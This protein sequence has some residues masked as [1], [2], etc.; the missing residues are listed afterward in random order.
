MIEYNIVIIGLGG[1]GF[2]H[3]QALMNLNMKTNITLI[4]IEE[5][6]LQ[7]AK[8][9]FN[10]M[11]NDNITINCTKTI[12]NIEGDIDVAIVATSS[13]VRRK[14]IEELANVAN[15]KYLILEK[16]LFPSI[17]DYQTIQELL[18]RKKIQTWVNCSRRMYLPYEDLRIAIKESKSVNVS[19]SGSNWGLGCNAIHMLD[20]IDFVSGERDGK[21]LC[22]GS[23]L[24][25][26]ILES[27]REGY[28]E[29]TGKILGSI[30]NSVSYMIESTVSGENSITT[31]IFTNQKLFVLDE[32]KN[33]LYD[34]KLHKIQ[35]PY[36]SQL[37]N[38]V[39][40]EILTTETCKLTTYERSMRLHLP[41]IRM[42]LS[43]YNETMEGNICPIT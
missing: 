4:D 25:D 31:T 33:F 27:K 38:L 26:S 40:E 32:S 8:E 18:Q 37:T 22:D 23:L 5:K 21:V 3:Y 13:K 1:F 36:Q 39:V 35:L 6:Q 7:R 14:V 24:D 2:R 16:V 10:S 17:D 28:I 43:K 29:F 12:E 11:Q 9:F 15:V 19:I 42:F 20:F 41:L 34:G 30:G